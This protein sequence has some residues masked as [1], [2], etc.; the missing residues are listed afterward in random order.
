MS[1]TP[2]VWTRHNAPGCWVAC[3]ISSIAEGVLHLFAQST[4]SQLRNRHEVT[5]RFATLV[6][7]GL[8][9]Q[10]SRVATH[11]TATARQRRLGHKRA[12]SVTKQLRRRVDSDD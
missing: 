12:R 5:T 8:R 4:S 9:V 7:Q 1:S 11:P 3:V 2:P 10:R 6:R